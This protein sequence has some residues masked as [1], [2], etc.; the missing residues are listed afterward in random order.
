MDKVD[1]NELDLDAITRFRHE[2][3]ESGQTLRVKEEI[4]RNDA[5]EP[6]LNHLR[7]ATPS[8]QITDYGRLFFGRTMPIEF[9]GATIRVSK[10]QEM[11]VIEGCLFNQVNEAYEL[12]KTDFDTRSTFQEGLKRFEKSI[13]PPKALREMI[14]NAVSHKEYFKVQVPIQIS[15]RSN[16]L[17]MINPGSLPPGWDIESLLT[18]QH[19][20]PRNQPILNAF[21][22]C[23]YVEHKGDGVGNI[24][25]DCRANSIF[26]PVFRNTASDFTVKLLLDPKGWLIEKG[27]TSENHHAIV[28]YVIENGSIGNSEVQE[29]TGL[30]E[31]QSTHLL[32]DL[33]P[34]L[35]RIGTTG[36]SVKYVL[37]NDFFDS[38]R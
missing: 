33:K 12:L 5:L 32:N 30:K 34:I 36:R 1:Q 38:T 17:S 25:E 15:I 26:P 9:S 21:W 4:L 8:G 27:F 18:K 37:L 22:A 16:E 23:Y 2:A 7:F 6:L 31:R 24:I 20:F 13:Y 19:S 11:R 10:G 3:L 28:K 29:I 35:K 14:M